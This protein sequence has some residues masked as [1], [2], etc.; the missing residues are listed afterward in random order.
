MKMNYHRSRLSE[1][2]DAEVMILDSMFDM[3]VPTSALAAERYSV[4]CNVDYSHGLSARE[5]D[6]SLAR[7]VTG[8][9]LS[10]PSEGHL[11]L[12]AKGGALWETER[13]PDWGIF[14][15]A[16]EHRGRGDSAG[17]VDVV[18]FER[19][20]AEAF[21]RLAI[22]CNLYLGADITKVVW[23]KQADSLIYWKTDVLP[24]AAT[25][26]IR[27]GPQDERGVER[28]YDQGW[29]WSD[30]NGLN[31]YHAGRLPKPT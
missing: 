22:D 13:Q 28:F 16:V 9:I 19:P 23:R 26:N 25:L 7:F 4:V 30:I 17:S 18:A 2:S 11:G 12:T 20:V 31:E 14:C 15:A 10:R 24:W 27:F 29:W 6:A 8:G 21:L 5:L 1:I 3:C